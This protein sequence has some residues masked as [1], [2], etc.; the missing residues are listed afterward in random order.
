LETIKYDIGSKRKAAALDGVK[1]SKTYLSGKKADKMVASCREA[2]VCTD[3]LAEIDATLVPLQEALK[4]SQDYMNGSDQ[5]RVATDKAYVAQ[6]KLAKLLT[7]LEEQM[8]P[9]NYATPVPEEYSDL[10]QLK[11]R[12]TVEM[13]VKKGEDGA[14]FERN[15]VNIPQAKM[16]MIIDGYA[17]A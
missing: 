3:V 16:V 14:T 2:K 5:E 4:E 7:Q 12:A 6:V 17:G 8:V 1:K 11:K 9:A 15:G 13:V 10:P